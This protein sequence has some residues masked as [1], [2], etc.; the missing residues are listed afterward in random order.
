[1]RELHGEISDYTDE[2]E[3][4]YGSYEIANCWLRKESQADLL[5]LPP[6]DAGKRR[7]FPV[8][9]DKAFIGFLCKM[10]KESKEMICL[11]SFM[12]Q[13][14]ELTDAILSAAQNGVRVYILTAGEEELARG[15]TDID[16]IGKL[17]LEDY[18][19]LLNS[20][21][22]KVLIRT[23]PHFHAKFLLVD[24]KSP[25]PI[26]IMMTCN[27]TVDAMTGKNLEAAI[28][29]TPSEVKSFFAQFLKAFWQESRHELLVPNRLSDIHAAP[30]GLV[31]GQT[32]HLVTASGSDTLRRRLIELIGSARESI[33]VT[34]WSF[35]TKHAVIS[36]L[37]KA[38]DR[39][40]SV[41]VYTR[42]AYGNTEAL[43]N[44]VSKGAKVVGHDRYHSKITIVDSQRSLIMTSNFTE[45]GLDTGFETGIELDS[46]ETKCFMSMIENWNQLCEWK[47]APKLT[48][49]DAP[50]TI[51]R[52]TPST[53][54]MESVEV[55]AFVQRDLSFHAIDTLEE[56]TYRPSFSNPNNSSGPKLFRKVKYVWKVGV[57]VLPKRATPIQS[58][59]TFQSPV[60]RLPNGDHFVVVHKWEE[61]EN[62]KQLA[63]R[64]KAR[65]VIQREESPSGKQ[66]TALDSKK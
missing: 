13:Q 11:S 61:I 2:Q 25:K 53:K 62:A 52:G 22:G 27:A 66:Q 56:P 47:L 10:V 59:E 43:A 58:K 17:K 30:K 57:P 9:I 12:L 31:F 63:K 46:E 50:R 14:S 45:R 21:T 28:T 34:G 19:H 49:N 29:L 23:A 15:D 3:I 26:G 18:K 44:L 64:F 4:D 33:I 35:G 24:P 32:S 39:G 20:M 6:T 37:E 40:V 51:L 54:K 60:Y 65:I 16:D 41:T 38:L 55:S 36:S 48:L 7:I 1:M 5:Y 8:P 42:P